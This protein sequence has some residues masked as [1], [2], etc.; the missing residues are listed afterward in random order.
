MSLKGFIYLLMQLKSYLKIKISSKQPLVISFGD[1]GFIR[2]DKAQISK[3]GL[4]HFFR[5][6]PFTPNV[7][8]VIKALDV[9]VMPSLS[10]ACGL[11]AMET[12]VA[13]IPLIA[14]NCIGLREVVR[15]TPAYVIPPR[16]GIALAKD[17]ELLIEKDRK[18]EF[19]MFSKEAANRFDVKEQAYKIKQLISERIT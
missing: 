17:L 15:D 3:R 13:G 7:A 18:Q 14:T 10:E 4:D 9:V 5:F 6:L 11:L 16:N 8:G 19:S 1:G 12:L 2:E